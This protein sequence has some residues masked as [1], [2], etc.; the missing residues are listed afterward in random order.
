MIVRVEGAHFNH[1]EHC[2]PLCLAQERYVQEVWLASR[3]LTEPSGTVHWYRLP[4]WQQI[5]EPGLRKAEALSP[6]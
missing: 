5:M 6:I 1:A 4:R 2:A 3:A